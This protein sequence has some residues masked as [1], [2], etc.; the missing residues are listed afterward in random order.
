MPEFEVW[1]VGPFRSYGSEEVSEPDLKRIMCQHSRTVVTA[2]SI[3]FNLSV[4]NS[5][6]HTVFRTPDELHP[7]ANECPP[8]GHT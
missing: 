5:L 2:Q 4:P 8:F 6:K 1:S 3:D 7:S